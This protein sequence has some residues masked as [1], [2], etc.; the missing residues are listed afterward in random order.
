[1]NKRIEKGERER[2]KERKKKRKKER[3]KES[4][5]PLL[6]LLFKFCTDTYIHTYI[7]TSC[8]CARATQQHHDFYFVPS[9]LFRH[10]TTN[11]KQNTRRRNTRWKRW[12]A[13]LNFAAWPA[14]LSIWGITKERTWCW[15]SRQYARRKKRTKTTIRLL[16]YGCRNVQIYSLLNS[17]C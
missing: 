3:K 16:A 4:K 8:T 11:T 9:T 14:S 2:K 12:N 15:P 1:M 13:Q 7:H 10:T 17:C 5:W 6:I